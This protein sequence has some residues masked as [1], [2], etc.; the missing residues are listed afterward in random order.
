MK[1]KYLI[2]IL[3]VMMVCVPV[4]QADVLYDNIGSTVF[5]TG[6]SIAEI[7][8]VNTAGSDGYPFSAGECFT[9]SDSNYSLTKISF[10]AIHDYHVTGANDDCVKVSLYSDAAGHLPG[11]TLASITINDLIDNTVD[12]VVPGAIVTVD[13]SSKGVT[14]EQGKSYWAVLEPGSN[15]TAV[16][17]FNSRQDKYADIVTINSYT[18]GSWYFMSASSCE[19]MY[20]SAPS[21]KIEG[22]PSGTPIVPEPTGLVALISG[23]AGAFIWRRK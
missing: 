19:A 17:W 15:T 16:G 18:K 4:A 7:E 14:L 5:T 20:F 6:Y 22:D 3:V 10:A 11:S 8:G 23:L 21:L 9:V 13:F 12:G 1:V 2:G